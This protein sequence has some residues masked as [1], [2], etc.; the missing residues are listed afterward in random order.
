MQKILT[1]LCR[2]RPR[3]NLWHAD[4]IDLLEGSKELQQLTK[5]LE[6]PA[7]ETLRN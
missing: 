7:A 4:D 1:H 3:C 6:K 2:G 5:R